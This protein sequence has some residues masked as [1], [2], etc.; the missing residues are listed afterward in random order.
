MANIYCQ[1]KGS[2][3]LILFPPSDVDR[4][5]FA[6]GSSSSS[7]NIFASE[8]RSLPP[9]THPWEASL[10]PGD[11][12]LIPRLWPH[13]A[14]PPKTPSSVA[15]NVFFR[16]LQSGYSH[17]R[18]V[19]GNRDLAAFEKGRQDIAKVLSNFQKLPS[20]VKEF[21]LKRLAEELI[22]GAGGPAAN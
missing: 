8:G 9:L 13:A 6:T 11:V 21:Y 7:V 2:K 15:V 17:G 5:S 4:L 16:D 20:D 3:R 19:Y 1:I 14:A 10:S 12:L 22:Q 18:D